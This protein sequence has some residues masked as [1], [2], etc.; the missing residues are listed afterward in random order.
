MSIY[1][2]PTHL[3]TCLLIN[4]PQLLSLITLLICSLYNLLVFAVPC[5]FVAICWFAGLRLVLC[6]VLSLV[7]VCA[8][9]CPVLSCP[10]LSCLVLPACQF[11]FPLRG[12][13]CLFYLL[14]IIKIQFSSCNWVLALFPSTKSDSI[15]TQFHRN[16][17]I[18]FQTEDKTNTLNNYLK[19][20][21]H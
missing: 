10:V 8:L 21:V 16:I 20:N 19:E 6:P 18:W 17:I 15:C 11:V 5:G 9:S 13:F 7:L 4:F 1:L 2:N 3:V 12:C 14:L